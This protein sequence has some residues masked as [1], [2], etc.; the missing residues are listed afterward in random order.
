MK[1]WVI[2]QDF[3]DVFFTDDEPAP[4]EITVDKWFQRQENPIRKKVLSTAIISSF[5][6]V[7]IDLVS[8]GYVQAIFT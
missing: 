6:V 7:R 3:A 2:Y 8:K 4:E 1:K 5:G